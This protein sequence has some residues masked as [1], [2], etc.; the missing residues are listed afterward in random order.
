SPY[1]SSG[2]QC[3]DCHMPIQKGKRIVSPELKAPKRDVNLHNIAGGHSIEQVKSALRV[4]I[5]EVRREGSTLQVGVELTNIGS[6]HK[7][8]TGTPSRKLVLKVVVRDRS[9]RLYLEDE[10]TFEKVLM[11]ENKEILKE[12][13]DIIL[14]AA[15]I[16]YDNRISPKEVREVR[17][18]FDIPYKDLLRDYQENLF[19]EARALYHYL[20]R[21]L[22]P[23]RMEI[24]VASDAVRP[25]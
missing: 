25:R 4:K 23:R 19:I 8:P 10:K 15:R 1:A 9:G 24:E 11:D 20:P 13:H 17:Y 21:V 16:F 22:A 7:I 3:Q 5:K 12:D 2:V 18:S 14:K 6:G